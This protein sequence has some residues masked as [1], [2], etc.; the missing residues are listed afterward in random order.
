MSGV[1]GRQGEEGCTSRLGC[2]HHRSLAVAHAAT[3]QTLG[4]FLIALALYVYLPQGFCQRRAR[5]DHVTGMTPG[6]PSA[7][8][9]PILHCEDEVMSDSEP[10][11]ADRQTL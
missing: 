8:L 10:D 7:P 6:R 2:G 1:H 11:L 5:I 3:L 4:L 9:L